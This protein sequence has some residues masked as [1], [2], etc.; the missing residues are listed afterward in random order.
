MKTPDA[1][2]MTPNTRSKAREYPM[3]AK[4]VPDR[5]MS[6]PA[7]VH[8][9]PCP[10]ILE[11]SPKKA[12]ASRRF[13]AA[14]FPAAPK[15]TLYHLF[16]WLRSL[17]MLYLGYLE[18]HPVTTKS[19]TAAVVSVISDLLAQWLIMDSA[20]DKSFLQSVDWISV[21][22]QFIIGLVMR[23]FPLHYWYTLLQWMFRRVDGSKTTTA[24]SKHLHGDAE[25]LSLSPR[26]AAAKPPPPCPLWVVAAKVALDQLTYGPFT[27]WLYFFVIGWFNGQSLAEIQ[28]KVS[29]EFLPIML[30][31]WRIWP[32]VTFINF[33]FVPPALQVL[34]GNIIAIFWTT[35]VVMYTRGA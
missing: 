25:L 11:S 4:G 1:L 21:R 18:S 15:Q 33:K 27:N 17:W 35:W 29:R 7:A 28:S 14:S 32:A 6:P 31:N 30:A 13:S 3:Q 26:P 8:S 16:S 12:R 2:G 9:A 19:I 23:G 5:S 10:P 34:F 24:A 20:A 22:T